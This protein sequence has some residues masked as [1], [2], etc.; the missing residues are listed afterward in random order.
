M[1][2]KKQIINKLNGNKDISFVHLLMTPFTGLGL[3]NGYRG[4]KWL[5][6]RIKIFKKYTLRSLLNQTNRNFV[7]WV[8]FRPEERTNPLVMELEEYMKTLD[9]YPFFFTYGGICFWDDKYPQDKLYER[10]ERTL[11]AVRDSGFLGHH[12]RLGKV[13]YVYQTIIASD[14]MYMD[15]AIE[16]IQRTYP[17]PK[18]AVGWKSGYMLDALTHRV[19]EYNPKTLPPFTTIIFPT[20][21]FLSP[22]QHYKYIGPYKSHEYVKDYLDVEVLKGRGFCVN[23]HGE[24]ISTTWETS[25][26]HPVSPFRGKDYSP[27]EAEEI[28]GRLGLMGAYATKHKR[29]PMIYLRDIS[30]KSALGRKAYQLIKWFYFKQWNK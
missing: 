6:Y 1:Q 29:R 2:D 11:P 10:L 28:R 23:V 25:G 15:T 4:D 3:H 27:E 30:C 7:H 5:A 24:N 20:E 12:A 8:T 18:K 14:D 21:T 16:A 22:A 13:A 19:A 26:M 17:S 9:N